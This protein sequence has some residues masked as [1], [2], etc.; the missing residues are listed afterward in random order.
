MEEVW[1]G[2]GYLYKGS[3]IDSVWQSGI[4]SFFQERCFGLILPPTGIITGMYI[5]FV[6]LCENEL[7]LA[8][9]VWWKNICPT[10]GK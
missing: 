9:M 1:I 3:L 4:K 5:F 6:Q 8:S 10:S 2:P 7:V